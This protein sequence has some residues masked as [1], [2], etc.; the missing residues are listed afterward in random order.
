MGVV[1]PRLFDAATRRLIPGDD[2]MAR[3]KIALLGASPTDG[4]TARVAT[5]EAI[6]DASMS[7]SW[8][9]F[10]S[11]TQNHDVPMY[12]HLE[13]ACRFPAPVHVRPAVEQGVMLEKSVAAVAGRM[14]TCQKITPALGK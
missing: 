1:K 14:V 13:A 9:P 4:K 12:R 2:G 5:R 10:P 8:L 7:R 3:N 11:K 6:G